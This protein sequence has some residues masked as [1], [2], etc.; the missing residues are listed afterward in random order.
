MA[1]KRCCAKAHAK[2]HRW[3]RKW[4][5]CSAVPDSP[6][7]SDDVIHTISDSL[8]AAASTI[9]HQHR[10]SSSAHI[11]NE[12]SGFPARPVLLD[13][14]RGQARPNRIIRTASVAQK[15]SQIDRSHTARMEH[16][17][18]QSPQSPL[19]FAKVVRP[20]LVRPWPIVRFRHMLRMIGRYRRTDWRRHGAP[21]TQQ[22]RAADDCCSQAVKPNQIRPLGAEHNHHSEHEPVRLP[23]LP[24]PSRRKMPHSTDLQ[25]LTH[26]LSFV[27]QSSRCSTSLD[28]RRKP[29]RKNTMRNRS[30]TLSPIHESGM[31]NPSSPQNVRQSHRHGADGTNYTIHIPQTIL[32]TP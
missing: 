18:N 21:V 22:Q 28:G 1:D 26:T 13:S 30:P 17:P 9:H 2:H 25:E 29:R 5:C 8:T 10:Q 4:N 20:R 32:D 24:P 6:D 27:Q 23:V 16:V 7:V 12:L 11:R 19:N 3:K 14:V 15:L 31:S